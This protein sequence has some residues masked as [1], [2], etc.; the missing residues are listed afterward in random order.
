MNVN[1]IIVEQL[2]WDG[3][4][5]SVTLKKN[6]RL[7]DMWVAFPEEYENE[8]NSPFHFLDKKYQKLF[9]RELNDS[10]I[11]KLTDKRFQTDGKISTL[12]HFGT[13][14]QRQEAI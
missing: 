4:L 8:R 5:K 1:G 6:N 11:A 3:L 12:P 2:E 13:V 10:R 7:G 14:C 9:D